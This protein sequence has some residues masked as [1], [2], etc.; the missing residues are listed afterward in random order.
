[1]NQDHFEG[2]D[3]IRSIVGGRGGQMAEGPRTAILNI[4]ID[5]RCDGHYRNGCDRAAAGVV[6]REDRVFCYGVGG[7]NIRLLNVGIRSTSIDN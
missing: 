3:D 5:A 1:M 4:N 2:L 7:F 6:I